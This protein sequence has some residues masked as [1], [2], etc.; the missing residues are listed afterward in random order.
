MKFSKE[1]IVLSFGAVT[2]HLSTPRF[3]SDIQKAADPFVLSGQKNG[4]R[5]QSI[6]NMLY[7][8]LN[9]FLFVGATLFL[10][11][12]I[13]TCDERLK[14]LGLI[15]LTSLFNLIRVRKSVTT[16]L[17]DLQR[18]NI[19][20]LN[21]YEHLIS[22]TIVLIELEQANADVDVV[23]GVENLIFEPYGFGTVT[24][25]LSTPRFSSDIQQAV[26]PFVLL[27]DLD[28]RMGNKSV[29]TKL[30]DLQMF[31]IF[32]LN[33]YEYLIS[34]T[35]VLRELEQVNADVDVVNGVENLIFEGSVSLWIEN[36]VESCTY[37]CSKSRQS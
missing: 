5:I 6:Y 30:F 9:P 2:S 34:E 8:S 3:T 12:S 21:T 35:I 37:F 7:N 17:F 4:Q 11:R 15:F 19:F 33:T 28:K 32:N 36:I 25:H 31:N 1:E 14:I 13:L 22:E 24:L 10:N 26:D 23:N 18:F 27:I 29:A 20:N 16:K